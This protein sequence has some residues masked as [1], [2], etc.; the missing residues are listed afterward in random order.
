[1]GR[2][3]TVNRTDAIRLLGLDEGFRPIDLRRARRRALIAHHPDHGGSREALVD[4]ERAAELLGSQPLDAG[5][6]RAEP[7]RRVRRGSDRPSFTIDVLPVDAFEILL[8]AA[9]ELADVCDDD[10]PYRLEVR[11][12]DPVD[13]WV[14]FEVVPDAGSSTVSITVESAR[15]IDIE[16]VRDLWITTINALQTP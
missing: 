11:M 6:S 15:G 2:V 16:A 7:G 14:T 3:S 1:M 10:P 8:L 4:V 12:L 13:T 5:P 9:A